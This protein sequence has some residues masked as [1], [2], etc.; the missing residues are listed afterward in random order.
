MPGRLDGQGLSEGQPLSLPRF[1]WFHL[2]FG[3]CLPAVA[4]MAEW[5][6]GWSA[7]AYANPI[8]NRWFLL[9]ALSVP[10]GNLIQWLRLFAA[11][12]IN[13][14]LVTLANRLALTVSLGYSLLFLPIDEIRQFGD[15]DRLLA[16][17]NTPADY[18][19][20]EALQGHKL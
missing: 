16:N 3:V 9:L 12:P 10:A 8:P 1:R 2:V 4:V 20:L 19:G 5:H 15:P 18:A 6:T 7:G 11:L 13:R 14:K 17:V